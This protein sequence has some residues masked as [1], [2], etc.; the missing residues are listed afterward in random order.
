MWLILVVVGVCCVG[1]LVKLVDVWVP[2]VAN[3]VLFRGVIA[4][5]VRASH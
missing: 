3:F 5:L 4:Q 2:W 1:C